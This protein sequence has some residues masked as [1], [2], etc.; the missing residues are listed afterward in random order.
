VSV[1]NVGIHDFLAMTHEFHPEWTVFAVEASIQDVERALADFH[2]CCEQ[3]SH[4]P[5]HLQTITS[6]M[7]S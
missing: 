4:V 3:D 1:N 7:L 2:Q 5:F 6:M